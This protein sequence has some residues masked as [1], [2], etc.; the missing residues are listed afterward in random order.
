MK[1]HARKK[2]NPLTYHYDDIIKTYLQ[3]SFFAK[4]FTI[5]EC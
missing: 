2:A 3:T 4:T 5:R 1:Y